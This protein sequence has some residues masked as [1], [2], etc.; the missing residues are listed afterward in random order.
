MYEVYWE[1]YEGR[2]EEPAEIFDTFEEACEYIEKNAD[3]CGMDE[4]YTIHGV[5]EKL[6]W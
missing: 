1:T 2:N 5:K 3:E 6:W 4:W